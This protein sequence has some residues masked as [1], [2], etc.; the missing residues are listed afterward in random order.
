[1]IRAA[2]QRGIE[3][4]VWYSPWIYLL[5][6]LVDRQPDLAGIHI[7]E[8]GFNWGADYCYCD[9]CRRLARDWFGIDLAKAPTAARV[10]LH[11]LAAFMC[12]DFFARLRQLVIQRRPHV[13]LSANGSGGTNPDWYIGRDWT[14]W[15]RR[16]YID[17][18]VPQLYTESV[19]TFIRQAERTKDRL[20]DCDL[21][22]GMAVS[23]SGIYP[24][25]QDPKVIAAEIAAARK[26]G[27]KGFC[28]FNQVYF[29]E[30]HFA[31]VRQAVADRRKR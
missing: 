9:H 3:V 17:F 15:A 11:N 27:A 7:E 14:T 26:L 20:G 12:T 30:E 29:F 8:P 21:V 25:R 6:K 2:R 13:W 31:A 18:Y 4:H 23:W 22:T 5:G 28:V 19:E 16:G 24:K 10:S 1:M